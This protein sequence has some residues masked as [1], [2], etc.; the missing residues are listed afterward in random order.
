MREKLPAIGDLVT[1]RKIAGPAMLVIG[2]DDQA[3]VNV[4]WFDKN[5]TYCMSAINAAFLE[6]RNEREIPENKIPS[7]GSLHGQRLGQILQIPRVKQYMLDRQHIQAIKEIRA[8]TGLGLK[9]AKDIVDQLR[10]LRN[11]WE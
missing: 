4:V 2:V 5:N 1:I 9:E 7:L 8:A 10:D 6:I 3:M 11:T